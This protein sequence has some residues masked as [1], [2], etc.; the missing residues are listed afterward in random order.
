MKGI[1]RHLEALPGSFRIWVYDELT[2]SLQGAQRR[3]VDSQP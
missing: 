3:I 1:G 2:L